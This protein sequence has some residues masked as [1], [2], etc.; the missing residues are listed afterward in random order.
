MEDIGRH[1]A[2]DKVIGAGLMTSCDFSNTV[3]VCSGRTSSEILHKARRCGMPIIL[4]RG[5]PTHQTILLALEMN[6]TVIG[7]A[8][9]NGFT[10][11]SHAE[12]VDFENGGDS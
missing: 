2:V 6:M 10:V 5:A 3:V 4:S 12:R 8:R 7:F 1:N 9:G 11:Y